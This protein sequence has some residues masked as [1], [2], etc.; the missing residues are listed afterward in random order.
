MADKI[1][2]QGCTYKPKLKISIKDEEKILTN[3]DIKKVD[4]LFGNVMKTYPSEDVQYKDEYYVINL[5]SK[6]TLS[7]PAG[8]EYNIEVIVTFRQGEKKP[9]DIDKTFEMESTGFP[10]EVFRDE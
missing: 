3:E 2:K 8:R 1:F 4:F 10:E 7:I 5:S 9:V 6:D